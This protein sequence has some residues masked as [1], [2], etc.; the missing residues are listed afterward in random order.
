MHT[1]YYSAHAY[2]TA[3]LFQCKRV[4]LI[5]K[6]FIN[7]VQKNENYASHVKITKTESSPSILLLIDFS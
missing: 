2:S 4:C 1:I 6:T 7:N 5:V 3:E